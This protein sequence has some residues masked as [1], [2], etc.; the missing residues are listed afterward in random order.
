MVNCRVTND[1]K[2]T[3]TWH[4]NLRFITSN[5]QATTALAVEGFGF[6]E[7]SS[8]Q[9]QNLLLRVKSLTNLHEIHEILILG[10]CGSATNW[11]HHLLSQVGYEAALY[12]YTVIHA[13]VWTFILL[14]LGVF[15]PRVEAG[16][17]ILGHKSGRSP[18][19][20]FENGNGRPWTLFRISASLTLCLRG[21][22]LMHDQWNVWNWKNSPQALP[23]TRTHPN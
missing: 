9:F 19:M 20:I 16:E 14:T 11:Q 22:S 3:G 6:L 13:T 15:V 7:E 18:F 5:F 2:S 23:A 21:G 8:F 10:Y 1:I 4:F 12:R 17:T